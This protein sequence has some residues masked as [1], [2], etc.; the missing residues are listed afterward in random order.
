M[1][2]KIID[3]KVVAGTAGNMGA[4]F[5]VLLAVPHIWVGPAFAFSWLVSGIIEMNAGSV[6]GPVIWF[7]AIVITPFGMHSPRSK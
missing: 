6:G 3:E 7:L 1:S 5:F 4:C 2:I